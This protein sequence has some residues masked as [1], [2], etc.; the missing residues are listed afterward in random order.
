MGGGGEAGA[1]A[2]GDQQSGGGPDRDPRNR[3]QD[4]GKRVSLQQ[5]PD[6]CFQS[7]SL[8][9]DGRERAGQRRDHDVERAG[10]GDDDGLLV[11]RVEDLVD[12]SLSHARGLGPDDFNQP[13]TTGLSQGGRRSVAFQQPGHGR[14]VQTRPEHPFQAGV[15]LGEQAAYPVGGAGGLGRQVLVEADQH[16]QLGGDFGGQ[17]QRAQ[18]VRHRPRGVSDH[19]RVA[20]VGLRLARVEIGDPPHR[21]ARGRSLASALGTRAGR[22]PAGVTRTLRGPCAPVEARDARHSPGVTPWAGRN[23]RAKQWGSGR[24]TRRSTQRPA[25]RCRSAVGPP[26]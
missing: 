8:F 15:E 7:S 9:V 24:P 1:I 5:L 4:R 10:P 11:K 21:D 26:R 20:G 6:L 12:Q 13:A 19:G 16:G 23:T 25:D 14:V 2:D 3:G 22:T 18:G 17:F